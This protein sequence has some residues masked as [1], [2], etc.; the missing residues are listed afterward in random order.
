M[1]SMKQYKYSIGDVY[2]IIS[3]LLTKNTHTH[4]T[5]APGIYLKSK[6]N[7]KTDKRQFQSF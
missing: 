2:I 5:A 7:A 4:K 6:L 3:F 1:S